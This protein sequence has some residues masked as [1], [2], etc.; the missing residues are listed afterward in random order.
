MTCHR[1]N[2]YAHYNAIRANGSAA[3]ENKRQ[4]ITV[5]AETFAKFPKIP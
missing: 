1:K 3:Y 5:K 4:K 2:N